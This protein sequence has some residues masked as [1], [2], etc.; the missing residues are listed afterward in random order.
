MQIHT[1]REL[2]ANKPDI[3]TKDHANKRCKLIDVSV[4]SDRNTSTRAIENLSKYKDLE[5]ETTRMWGMRTETV[6]DIVGCAGTDQNLGKI[7][8]CSNINELQRS[9]SYERCISE[10]VS[11]HQIKDSPGTSPGPRIEY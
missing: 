10:K 7:H 1:D 3:V 11:V 5:I 8:G 6:P 4:P 2:S 9:L